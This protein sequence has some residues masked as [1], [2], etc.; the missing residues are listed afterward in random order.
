MGCIPARKSDTSKPRVITSAITSEYLNIIDQK[1]LSSIRNQANFNVKCRRFK[2]PEPEGKIFQV[3]IKSL[4][5]S[6]IFGSAEHGKEME[7]ILTDYKDFI[8]SQSFFFSNIHSV[9]VPNFCLEK[10]LIFMITVL[11]ANQLKVEADPECPYLKIIGNQESVIE[12]VNSW[13]GFSRIL[14]KLNQ[15]YERINFCKGL[16]V[17]TSAVI[18]KYEN[19]NEQNAKKRIKYLKEIKDFTIGFFDSL[20]EMMQRVTIF[21]DFFIKNQDIIV[22]IGQ[23]AETVKLCTCE[24]MVHSCSIEGTDQSLTHY[25]S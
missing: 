10:G 3:D 25:N 18:K 11:I 24:K 22:Q 1:L 23:T 16:L 6:G 21:A 15:K 2:I 20:R 14:E 12:L 4:F 9:C 13:N 19:L 17:K 5:D 7:V 8:S